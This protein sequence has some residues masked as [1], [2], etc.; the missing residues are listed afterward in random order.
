MQ[1]FGKVPSALIFRQ[2]PNLLYVGNIL[3]SSSLHSLTQFVP[4]KN[5]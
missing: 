1:F 4:F 5:L 2:A 3:Y